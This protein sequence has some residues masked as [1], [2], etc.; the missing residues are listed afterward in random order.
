MHVVA[1][2]VLLLP[3]AYV[4]SQELGLLWALLGLFLLPQGR[5]LVRATQDLAAHGRPWQ[6]YLI[7][8]EALLLLGVALLL[9]A[10]S[11]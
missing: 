7:A 1:M 10:Y 4:V 8:N 3:I 5:I 11:F 2:L 9:V 6:Q